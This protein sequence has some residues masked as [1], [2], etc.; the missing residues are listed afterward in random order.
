[1]RAGV[2]EVG[3]SPCVIR[4]ARPL[5]SPC[6]ARRDE[7]RRSLRA[8][9]DM[10]GLSRGTL[11]LLSAVARAGPRHASCERLSVGRV[12]RR[13]DNVCGV[14]VMCKCWFRALHLFLYSLAVYSPLSDSSDAALS[15][16]ECIGRRRARVRV[17]LYTRR[18]RKPTRRSSRSSTAGRS[19]PRRFPTSRTGASPSA[20]A[21]AAYHCTSPATANDFCLS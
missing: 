14:G 9:A 12:T 3:A 16:L 21:R 15:P 2:G 7:G 8:W 10:Y 19:A 13:C 6:A 17:K 4:A 11:G 1:M 18:P 20:S 5:V